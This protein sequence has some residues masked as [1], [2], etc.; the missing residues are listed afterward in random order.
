LAELLS[1]RR[2]VSLLLCLLLLC[3]PL[4]GQ[5]VG[6]S[7]E[8]APATVFTFEMEEEASGEEGSVPETGEAEW[9]QLSVCCL[10]FTIAII[11]FLKNK[12]KV[13]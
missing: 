9:L 5:A 4:S 3:C 1:L 7:E 6:I 12:Q 11:L 2:V 8:A 13:K 10:L